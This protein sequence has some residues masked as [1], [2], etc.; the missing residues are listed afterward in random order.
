MKKIIF[1]LVALFL[2]SC[3]AIP[4]TEIA[5][6][7]DLNDLQPLPTPAGYE[8]V[9]LRVAVAAVISPKGT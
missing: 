1:L 2:V 9:P 8:A 3:S 5:G 7:V 4:Q 6:N